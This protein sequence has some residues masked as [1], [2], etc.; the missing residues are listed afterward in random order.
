MSETINVAITATSAELETALAKASAAVGSFERKARSA[1]Q[2]GLPIM[3]LTPASL[4]SMERAAFLQQNLA[5]Q[6]MLAG[7]SGK[8]GSLGFLAFSQA[9]EDAQ[10]GIKGVL[11]NIP[12]MILGFGGTAG[13]AGVMSLAAVA[14]YGAYQAFKRFSGINEMLDWAK[15]NTKA[16]DAFTDSLRKS[17][18]EAAAL[19][20]EVQ[21]FNRLQAARTAGE[22]LIS[23]G[24]VANST[25]L[26]GDPAG[27]AARARSRAAQQAVINAATSGSASSNTA[28]Q[29]GELDWR[30]AVLQYTLDQKNLTA[31][32]AAA[33][34]QL[35]SSGGEYSRIWSNVGDLITNFR[36]Q[37]FDLL[38]QEEDIR[39]N[40]AARQAEAARLQVQ[41]ESEKSD[42][43]KRGLTQQLTAKNEEIDLIKASLT[44]KRKEIELT[45][46]LI[47]KTQE[48]GKASAQALDARVSK[49]K[50][51][52]AATKDAIKA[53]EDLA[54]V[55]A[56]LLKLNTLNAQQS[57]LREAAEKAKTQ[58]EATNASAKTIE[59]RASRQALE[60]TQG[61][62]MAESLDRGEAML[63]EA[64]ALAKGTTIP[65]ATIQK[66]LQRQ[67]QVQ[68]LIDKNQG[69]VRERREVRSAERAADREDRRNQKRV[70]AALNRE[71]RARARRGED[72]I[73]QPANDVRDAAEKAKDQNAA[74]LDAVNKNLEGQTKIQEALQK[75]LE[76][77]EPKLPTV[78]LGA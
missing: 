47:K 77:I 15:N 72:P 23:N 55:E 53:R 62:G 9:V 68:E 48:E 74:A 35:N 11:N 18:H 42:A 24:V 70:Q 29:Q 21:S 71:N 32:L 19:A 31:D 16:Q 66:E 25:I 51:D 39:K 13:L 78:A 6:T 34:E 60:L 75:L 49:L 46:E 57:E 7:A 43:V 76:K 50:E 22:S 3:E 40:L 30:K 38:Q 52:I 27:E 5:R 2:I 10:Y 4:A 73:D 17:R 44:E 33:Q 41:I 54:R 26:A 56:Q 67:A 37:Q 1:R 8:S 63:K 65:T 12:Q 61:R 28:L 59:D 69:T 64:E 36:N 20:E 14:A 58:L 45:D